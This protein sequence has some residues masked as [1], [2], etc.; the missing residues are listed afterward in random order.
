MRQRKKPYKK[1]TII[2]STNGDWHVQYYYEPPDAPGTWKLFKRR[3]GINY[4][5]GRDEK[6]K[7]AQELRLDVEEWLRAG[8]GP[9]D[10]DYN[11]KTQIVQQLEQV[12]VKKVASRRWTI[13]KAIDEF[14]KHVKKQGL[15]DRT[16][17]TYDNYL[18]NLE[19]YIK[20]NQLEG[21]IASEIDEYKII[22]FLDLE[23]D[24]LDWSARTYN[25][26]LEF[27][28]TFFNRCQK[29][30][31]VERRKIVYDFDISDI[32]LKNTTPQK[33]KAYTPRLV[34]EIKSTTSKLGYK[35]LLEYM[36]WIYLS[37]MRPE[38]IRSLSFR[39]IDESAR[40]IR[41][42]GKT[43]DRIIP[44]SDQLLKLIKK[45]SSKMKHFNDFVF[46][47]AGDVSADRMG[48]DYFREQFKEIRKDLKLDERYGLYSFKHTSVI[49]MIKAG[50]KDNEIRVLSG[51][52]TQ[53]AFEAYKRDLVIDN[54]HVMKGSTID[55]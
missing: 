15:A 48:G 38:E 20:D 14:R 11:V 19:G 39:D 29:L 27:Y 43:G 24:N 46:G 5:K 34:K 47:K 28:G 3:A 16:K 35:N 49:A 52:K 17:Q 33:N 50:F 41:I 1:P 51:H 23:S 30:E 6:E 53:A 36:E 9:Y 22:E 45:R 42:I 21:L 10:S 25:N 12:E 2:R 54:S 7:A 31:R 44:I 8:N 18:Y 4:I 13:T 40:Q 55:F 32:D 26:Y 37:L